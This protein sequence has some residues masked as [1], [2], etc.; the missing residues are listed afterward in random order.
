MK[1]SVVI[2]VYNEEATVE[3]LLKQVRAAEVPGLE[4]EVLVV[5]DASTDSTPEILRRLAAPG[6]LR[7]L[8]HPENRGKGAA[9][10]TGFAAATGDVVLVQA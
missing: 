5:D 1:L 6:D 7:V 9:L 4:K 2:P 3:A 10:A 8:T